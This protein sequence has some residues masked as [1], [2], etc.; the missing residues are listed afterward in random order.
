MLP[1][2]SSVVETICPTRGETGSLFCYSFCSGE[3]TC[4]FLETECK[5]LTSSF[6]HSS[7]AETCEAI[8]DNLLPSTLSRVLG[9]TGNQNDFF[10]H[11]ASYKIH[12][13]LYYYFTRLFVT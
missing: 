1:R 4:K 10:S 12:L 13:S 8:N 5:I 7:L 2:N 3:N 6:Q 9:N 11:Q